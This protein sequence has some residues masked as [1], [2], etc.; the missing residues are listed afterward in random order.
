MAAPEE[1]NADMLPFGTAMAATP[2]VY[3]FIIFGLLIRL[4]QDVQNHC[5][6]H[7]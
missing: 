2:G 5:D 6:L 7:G 3:D 4:H 1:I